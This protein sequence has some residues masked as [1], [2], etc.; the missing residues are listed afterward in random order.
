MF[1]SKVQIRDAE[2]GVQELFLLDKIANLQV[3][4]LHFVYG[5]H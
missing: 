2:L 1:I 4:K 5:I 3:V